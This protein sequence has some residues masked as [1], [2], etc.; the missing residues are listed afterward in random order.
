MNTSSRLNL[1][2]EGLIAWILHR[3]RTFIG[4]ITGFLGGICFHFLGFWD[5]LVLIGCV[6]I[7]LLVGKYLDERHTVGE[8][9]DRLFTQNH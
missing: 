7:G 1:I 2:I 3:P 5:T 4:V 8:V 9:L 6:L